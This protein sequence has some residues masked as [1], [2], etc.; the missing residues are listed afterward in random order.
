MITV[1]G[2]WNMPIFSQIS[3][4]ILD[5][6]M[7]FHANKSVDTLYKET[8]DLGNMQLCSFCFNIINDEEVCWLF[9]IVCIFKPHFNRNLL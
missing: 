6:V 1:L 3:L 5:I 8:V 2:L 9:E 4:D 7:V